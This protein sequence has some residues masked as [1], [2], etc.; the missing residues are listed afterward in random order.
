MRGSGEN[1]EL[2]NDECCVLTLN[3]ENPVAYEEA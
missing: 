2:G 3:G 1:E